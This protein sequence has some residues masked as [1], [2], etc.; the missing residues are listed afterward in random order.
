MAEENKSGM[1]RSLDQDELVK[2]LAPDSQRP[3]D[4]RMLNG[5]L[6]K[7]TQDGYWRL[8]LT[9][10]LTEYVEFSEEDVIHSQRLDP[11]QSPLG[12]T[13]VWVRREANL[14]HTRPVSPEAHT[15]FLQGSITAAF[16][17][18]TRAGASLGPRALEVL[19]VGNTDVTVCQTCPHSKFDP[20]CTLA[21][22][23]YTKVVTD[24]GCGGVI[25]L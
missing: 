14:T 2:S 7:S 1:T 5:F 24:P 4:V 8:Y 25:F 3:P 22:S 13:V 11:N 6:G 19:R 21:T 9:P 16:L 10:E 15:E 18:G 17:R 12:G 20:V 23:C